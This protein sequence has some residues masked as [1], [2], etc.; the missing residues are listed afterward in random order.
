MNT[1]FQDMLLYWNICC[2]YL[3]LIYTVLP[4]M[5]KYAIYTYLEYMRNCKIH[6]L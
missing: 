2:F 5:L 1:L 3:C 6:D 4:L